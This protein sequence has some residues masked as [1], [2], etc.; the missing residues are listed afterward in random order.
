MNSSPSN[1]EILSEEISQNHA[2]SLSLTSTAPTIISPTSLLHKSLTTPK[3]IHPFLMSTY[4]TLEYASKA[5][6]HYL[7]TYEIFSCVAVFAYSP[8]PHPLAF[9]AHISLETLLGGIIRNQPLQTLKQELTKTFATRTKSDVIVH[10]VGGHQNDNHH[11][12]QHPPLYTSIKNAITEC[13]FHQIN[14]SLDLK[15]PGMN[16][17]TTNPSTIWSLYSQNQVFCIAA[18]DMQSGK[19]VT[20]TSMGHSIPL[21][22]TLGVANKRSFRGISPGDGHDLVR[23]C[24]V[25]GG[26]SRGA[27][28][29]CH[30][31]WYCGK[32]C[33]RGDWKGIRVFVGSRFVSRRKLQ[34]RGW[35]PKFGFSCVSQPNK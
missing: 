2:A 34:M 9:A 12:T 17:T 35:M 31:V 16:A 25:C 15:F 21:D 29:R 24:G 6:P 28:A 11:N 27:C 18:L 4:A 13:G 7:T 14:E 5:C 30:G 22:D 26:R 19:I 10:L 32:E 8:T 1:D 33:Q 23:A 20:H 3:N